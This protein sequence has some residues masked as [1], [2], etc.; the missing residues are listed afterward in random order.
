[1][2]STASLPGAAA[3]PVEDLA[4]VIRRLGREERAE[5]LAHFLRLDEK[6][7]YFRFGY[8]AA[9]NTIRRYCEM[10]PVLE[11]VI[12][13]A[14]IGGTLR[15]IAEIRPLENAVHQEAE[16]A[17]SIEENWQ[18]L[19]LGHTLMAEAMVEARLKGIPKLQLSCLP[20]NFRMRRLAE[21]FGAHVT[22]QT[23]QIRCEFSLQRP[24]KLT[25][26]GSTAW[27]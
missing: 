11:P 22:R 15:G 5:M 16:L 21:Q 3:G 23:G 8:P 14:F 13:G 19:G 2:T 1:M 27:Q 4:P 9:E 18:S 10:E 12:I 26:A 17:F 7:R 6:S 25:T 24:G 20:D